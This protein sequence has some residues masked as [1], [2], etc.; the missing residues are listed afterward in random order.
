MRNRYLAILFLLFACSSHVVFSQLTVTPCSAL[1]L[2]PQQFVQNFLV[3]QGVTVSNVTF[4][5]SSSVINSNQLGS[6]NATSVAYNELG[7]AGGILLTSG[8]ATNAIGPNNNCNTS[9]DLNLPGDPDL[10]VIAGNITT[11]DACILEFD[12]VPIA[13][14]LKFR[15]EFGSEEMY[16]YYMQFNDA[17]GFF[18]S[19]PG[20]TGPFSNNSVD[21][22]L[23]PGSI[24]S[25]VTINNLCNDFTSSWCNSPTSCPSGQNPPAY[26]NCTNPHGGGAY[27]Q[28][29]AFSWVFTAWHL[30]TPCQTYH[31]KIAV[32]DALDHSLDSG[33]FLE[34]NSFSA[35]GFTV[36][37]SYE[38]PAIG[39]TSVEGCSDA[40]VIFKLQT[41]ALQNDTINYTI[42][43]TATNGVDYT[44][45][46]NSVIIPAGMDSTFI[47]I[48]PFMD[49]IPEGTEN[50]TIDIPMFNCSGGTIYHDT[51]AILDNFTLVAHAGND[52]TVCQGQAVTLHAQHTG[53]QPTYSY[54][55]NTGS[56]LQQITVTPPLGP[57]I[58]YVDITDG[59]TA[60]ARDTVIVN[61][62]AHPVITNV[63]LISTVCTGSHTNIV[64]QSNPPA[65]NFTWTAT[66]GNLNI[67]G[68]AAGNGLT[69]NQLL[70]NTGPSTDTVTY[71]VTAIAGGCTSSV[72]KDFKVAVVPSADA[73]FQPNGQS[74]C[75]SGTTAINILSHFPV[76]TYN[77]T[78]TYGTGNL[79]G[80]SNS[81]GMQI[82]QTLHN[83]GFTIDTVTYHVIPISSGC[84]GSVYNV[85]VAV[86]PNP[87]SWST[88]ASQSVCGGNQTSLTLSSHVASP[89]FTWTASCPSPNIGGYGPGVGSPIQQTLT[90][91]G[92]TSEVVTYTVTPSANGCIGTGVTT[93]LVTVNPTPTVT[94]PVSYSVCSGGP[95][96]IILH[97]NPPG[98]TYTWT[99]SGS[100]GNVIGFS[101]GSGDT[102]A[103]NPVNTGFSNEAVTYGVTA[104]LLGCTALPFNITVTVFPV[105]DVIFTP[106]G[107][108]ICSGTAPSIALTSHVA[109]PT[110]SW[111]ATGS[112]GNISGFG[113]D[114]GTPISQVLTNSG[115][116]PETATYTVNPTANGCPGSPG[117][118]IITVNPLA[119][120]TFSTC[121]DVIT[122]TDAL[123]FTLK[124]G[125]PVGGNYSGTG[126]NA[127]KFFPALAGTGIHAITYS[128]SNVFGCPNTALLNINVQNP[129]P[130][131]CDNPVTDVRDNKQYPTVTLGTQC[132]MAVN[133]DYGTRIASTAM[134]RDNCTVEKYCLN[135]IAANCTSLG[136]LY[137]WDEL[138]QFE[139]TAGIQGLC[140]PGWHIPQESEWTT[141]FNL[142]TGSGFAGAPL[143][144][145]GY[146]G[147]NVFLNGI[148]FD[149]RVW[150]FDTF[151][152]FLWSSTS[153]GPYKAW[154]H[155]M[156]SFNPS[157]S[158]YPGN[159]SNAFY[160]RCL[161]N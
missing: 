42:G 67:S 86:Y 161:K 77:W 17:F 4:N 106:P 128:Y 142:Y 27:L 145:T 155:A 78:Y 35:S 70:V 80:A 15:Y 5:G 73:Y 116:G 126:V 75:N 11:N 21:I 150:N 19:G 25:Y 3:G 113:P 56:T 153:H 26:I 132:W 64:P 152:T 110:Y 108:T 66:C 112:S 7:L 29:N 69:I 87:D 55:W 16:T 88:P 32:A 83:S 90:N 102:I 134:Q 44:L 146:S 129:L 81:S 40:T 115:S 109:G 156:N 46:P 9:A 117:N 151:A 84:A 8:L 76:N 57:T 99:A 54:L 1:G 141:L 135:D 12:F 10:S 59:C 89:T 133:L 118:V 31:I 114:V 140:P 24:N 20:I 52:T 94:N 33:V 97:S 58:Y 127:G 154:A 107:Q 98:S 71:H 159:R 96:N 39:Y 6:F 50:V 95:T 23:M 92:A 30:V 61:A 43:G 14:T 122:T 65:T 2:T 79:S 103:Q 138:M 101:G 91:S 100:S 72:P 38:H 82:S 51:I 60:V 34:E 85:K 105:A 68:Y 22:A 160:V 124:G 158:F 48:H 47:V 149:N 53:G 136:A 18:L 143:K 45:I 104:T 28:Y 36:T 148:R 137:Q 131:F 74:V 111:N 37:N 49:N 119:A 121:N 93:V 130:F 41:A 147:F 139:T 13:D 157:V 123:P 62:V 144:S 120:V 63:N 125:I